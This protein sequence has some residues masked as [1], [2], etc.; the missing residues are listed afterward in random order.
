MGKR[1]PPANPPPNASRQSV[2]RSMSHGRTFVLVKIPR[3]LLRTV[4]DSFFKTPTVRVRNGY[5]N[6][7]FSPK[8]KVGGIIRQRFPMLT[9]QVSLSS[10]CPSLVHRTPNYLS[11]PLRR[12]PLPHRIPL[13][14]HE[15]LYT[16][17]Q[18]HQTENPIVC[19]W[20]NSIEFISF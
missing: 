18:E 14:V 6:K 11:W 19:L 15:N 20:V 3:S 1:P 17:T 5:F 7:V 9:C 8:V 2:L 12:E 13:R 4:H 10:F 16:Y